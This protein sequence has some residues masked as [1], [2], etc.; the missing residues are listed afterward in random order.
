[1]DKRIYFFDEGNKNMRKLLGGK[2]SSLAEM[3]RINLPVPFGCTITT[4][5][6]S[7]YLKD[8]RTYKKEVNDEVIKSV[9]QIEK[10]TNKY[11]GDKKA[12]LF[13]AVRSGA[14]HSM[15]G[16]MDTVLNIGMN[17][18]LVREMLEEGYSKS[19]LFTTYEQFIVSFAEVVYDVSTDELMNYKNLFLF[20]AKK[21][22][23]CHLG[24][25]E[26][27]QLINN[28]KSLILKKT[29]KYFS[30]DIEETILL[31]VEAI[32]ASWLK[33]NAVMYR[34]I[35]GISDD[36][37]TAVNVQE[38]VFGNYN[39]ISGTG[40]IFTKNPMDGSNKI[41]GEYLHCAQGAELVSGI[42]NPDSI[43]VFEERFPLLYFELEKIGRLLEKH[44]EAPQDIE[45][46]V[47]SG[48]LYILQTRNAIISK[49]KKKV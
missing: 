41:V 45:F 8:N 25:E 34:K 38:M 13:L 46:S 17:E 6:I 14:E 32:A 44:Y 11:L 16:M 19:F 47:E 12:P 4:E 1:M 28:Y 7:R 48:K 39:D 49:L 36:L 37:S 15:P 18:V 26:Y 35:K 40:V 33:P 23:T 29:G 42:K 30:E 24:T 2:G 21:E 20:D 5:A 27:F 10:R 43:E 9:K 22:N 3:T 31:A